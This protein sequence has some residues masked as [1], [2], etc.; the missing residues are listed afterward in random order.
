MLH[1]CVLIDCVVCSLLDCWFNRWLF[2]DFA[3]YLLVFST[4]DACGICVVILYWFVFDFVCVT[5]LEVVCIDY[6]DLLMF[7]VV[8]FCLVGFVLW[9]VGFW[10]I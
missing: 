9:D 4:E 6:T 5:C 7:L 2:A 3:V 1:L 8:V 10:L